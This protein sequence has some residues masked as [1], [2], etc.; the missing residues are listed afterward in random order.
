M[1]LIGLVLVTHLAFSQQKV[2]YEY[3]LFDYKQGFQ[4]SNVFDIAE[5]ENGFFWLATER[6]MVRFDGIN[7]LD[8]NPP[9]TSLNQARVNRL[10]R[11]KNFLYLI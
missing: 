8:F 7:F 9:N 10:Y 4:Q 5:G 2:D 1:F 6:G 11:Y 3:K